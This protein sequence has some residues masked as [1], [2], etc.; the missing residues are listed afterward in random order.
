MPL[1]IILP[2]TFNVLFNVVAPDILTVAKCVD[3][4]CNM[5]VPLTN[6]VDKMYMD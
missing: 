1:P 5:D 6:N 3:A 4:F 2:I